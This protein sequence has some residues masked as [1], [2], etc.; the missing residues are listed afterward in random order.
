MTEI[1]VLSNTLLIIL[2]FFYFCQIR[3]EQ[4]AKHKIRDLFLNYRPEREI[5]DQEFIN[6]RF[7]LYVYPIIKF[8]E[9]TDISKR[10]F[11]NIEFCYAEILLNIL[12]DYNKYQNEKNHF[13]TLKLKIRFNNLI[14]YYSKCFYSSDKEVFLMSLGQRL[15][16]N[17][18][19]CDIDMFNFYHIIYKILNM[20][21]LNNIY[22]IQGLENYLHKNE[23][24]F[25][26]HNDIK[27][28]KNEIFNLYKHCFKN[29][30]EH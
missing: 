29:I 3:S 9:N 25:I 16:R 2:V 15:I 22:F 10:V 23:L 20:I 19:S 4:K 18:C 28:D 12:N 26:D 14:E 7:L 5:R 13:M 6:E 17:M 21:N 24:I 30:S 27:I 8:F 1:L 11:K